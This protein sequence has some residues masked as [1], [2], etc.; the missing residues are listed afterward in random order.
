M[1]R[2]FQLLLGIVAILELMPRDLV[3]AYGCTGKQKQLRW[4]PYS[5]AIN[6]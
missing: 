4:I 3:E 1:Q 5:K 2:K 6:T